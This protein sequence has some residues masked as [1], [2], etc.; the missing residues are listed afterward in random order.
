MSARA[1]ESPLSE[2]PN[3]KDEERDEEKDAALAEEP[4]AS[5]EP[6]M[7]GTSPLVES[8]VTAVT[9]VELLLKVEESIDIGEEEDSVLTTDVGSKKGSPCPPNGDT[10]AVCPELAL[11]EIPPLGAMLNVGSGG[12]RIVGARFPD[13]FFAADVS[14][15]A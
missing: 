15:Q 13:S 12:R 9:G 1:G 7:K 3:S 11:A 2:L 5:E 6:K 4:P 14:S 8:G 10:A